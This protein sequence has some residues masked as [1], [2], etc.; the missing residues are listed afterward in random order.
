MLLLLEIIQISRSNFF[1]WPVPPLRFNLSVD[2]HS[3]F[4]VCCRSRNTGCEE[5]NGRKSHKP[6]ATLNSES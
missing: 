1:S 5:S 4:N 2:H 3:R 6:G